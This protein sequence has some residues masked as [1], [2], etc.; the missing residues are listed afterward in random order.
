M[1][2]DDQ[3]VAGI[4]Q[5]HEHLQQCVDVGDVQSGG[6]FIEDVEGLRSAAFGEFGRELDPLRFASRQRAGRLPEGEIAKADFLH[7]GQLVGH[8]GDS[9]EKGERFVDGH[10][11]NVGDIFSFVGDFQRFAVVAASVADV[12]GDE[13]IGEKM[14][15]DFERAVALAVLAASAFDIEAEASGVVSAHACG[16]DL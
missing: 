7:G 2:D 3:G 10:V 6:R 13:D 5:F 9:A 4:A 8:R 15:F 1:L 12:A 14:H 11:E 16:G